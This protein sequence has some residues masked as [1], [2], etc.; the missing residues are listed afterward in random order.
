MH[1]IF[2]ISL[3]KCCFELYKVSF[4]FSFHLIKEIRHVQ[5]AYFIIYRIYTSIFI[6]CFLV[7]W[8]YGLI[9]WFNHANFSSK[10]AVLLLLINILGSRYQDRGPS[11]QRCVP[12]AMFFLCHQ[13]SQSL[14]FFISKFLLASYLNRN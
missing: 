10:R 8:V 12:W 11:L 14:Y 7:M 3:S 9:R 1:F 2:L 13:R 5:L 4:F 6:C